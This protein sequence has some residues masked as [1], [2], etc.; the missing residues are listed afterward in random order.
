ML[1]EDSEIRYSI[2]YD[3]LTPESVKLNDFAENGYEVEDA[4]V[5]GIK[6]LENLG[7]DFGII[8]PSSQGILTESDYFL[9]EYLEL[10]ND[11]SK[12]FNLFIKEVNGKPPSKL[13]MLEISKVLRVDLNYG[14]EDINSV[15]DLDK[16]GNSNIKEIVC[17]DYEQKEVISKRYDG[18]LQRIYDIEFLD[19][20]HELIKVFKKE[21]NEFYLHRKKEGNF[22][23][24]FIIKEDFNL[25]SAENFI[26]QFDLLKDKSL[27]KKGDNP[28]KEMTCLEVFRDVDIQRKNFGYFIF[29]GHQGEMQKGFEA[30]FLDENKEYVK[31]N[32]KKNGI[33]F[34][35]KRKGDKADIFRI[36]DDFNLES[37][38]NFIKQYDSLKNKEEL[39]KYN[40]HG[41]DNKKNKQKKR[42]I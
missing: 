13:D 29:N 30:E 36:K 15:G 2:T 28:I 3:V 32:N 24:V 17:L 8:S 38:K 27:I 16:K 9:S 21:E 14:F 1:N 23:D 33:Y 22:I 6:N 37:A 31:V 4:L 20:K 26:H 42:K 39:G 35:E 10:E 18:Q 12:R 34:L 25:A 41:G 7:S 5:I 11:S 40:K 19:D